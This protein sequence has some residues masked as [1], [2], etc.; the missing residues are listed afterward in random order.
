MC[1]RCSSVTRGRLTLIT[2]LRVSSYKLRTRTPHLGTA[3]ATSVSNKKLRRESSDCARS[4]IPLFVAHVRWTVQC[5]QTLCHRKELNLP[6]CIRRSLE[7]PQISATVAA[8][9]Q[10]EDG[11]DFRYFSDRSH[12]AAS[13]CR[14][15]LHLSKS[16]FKDGC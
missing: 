9:S 13:V 7:R 2:H 11:P 5:S 1:A 16:N 12:A 14:P 10:F 8:Q 6:V 3:S 4:Q 15:S